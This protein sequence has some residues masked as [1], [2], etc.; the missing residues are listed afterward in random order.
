MNVK[1]GDLA[2]VVNDPLNAGARVTVIA[3]VGRAYEDIGVD[4]E[5][6]VLSSM[7]AETL[8]GVVVDLV[9]GERCGI[10]DSNLRRIDPDGEDQ[11]LAWAG[12][13]QL[14]REPA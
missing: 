8:D 1:P 4:W 11:T 10:A 6:V 3:P 2:K 14:H 9:P 12:L 13:P 7:R 5:V